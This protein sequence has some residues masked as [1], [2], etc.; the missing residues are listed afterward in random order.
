MIYDSTERNVRRE[1]RTA[2]DRPE[3]YA[4]HFESEREQHARECGLCWNKRPCGHAAMLDEQVKAQP[5]LAQRGTY[6]IYTDDG[7]GNGDFVCDT[8]D[9]WWAFRIAVAL[10]EYAGKSVEDPA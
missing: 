5:S 10:D 6:A 9:R 7:R 2:N 3:G 4:V 1:H 8:G